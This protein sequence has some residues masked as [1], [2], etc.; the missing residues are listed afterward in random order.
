MSPKPHQNK[1]STDNDEEAKPIETNG[2]K[3]PPL[4]IV[5]PGGA[6]GAANRSE[7]EGE[8]M[9]FVYK[10]MATCNYDVS[11]SMVELYR[12]TAVFPCKLMLRN[13]FG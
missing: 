1:D 10:V 11:H 4:K 8:G 13:C 9:T 2:P 12:S 5:I 7:Q 6:A 3:V